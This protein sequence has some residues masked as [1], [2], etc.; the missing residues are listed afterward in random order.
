M[1]YQNP[2]G[3]QFDEA[4]CDLL[5]H[6]RSHDAGRADAVDILPPQV[7]ASVVGVGSAALLHTFDFVGFFAESRLRTSTRR[8]VP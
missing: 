5:E 2:A 8:A 1:C 7:A 3:E 4:G 6:W